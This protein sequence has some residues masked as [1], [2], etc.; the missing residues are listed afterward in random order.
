M[1]LWLSYIHTWQDAEPS[2]TRLI[3]EGQVSDQQAI[4]MRQQLNKLQSLIQQENHTDWYSKQYRI[5]FEQD[6][7]TPSG[8]FYRPDRVILKDNHAIVIDYKFGY[9]KHKS[10]LEQVRNYMLLLSQMGYT[11]EGHIVYNA[12]Q[13][14]H[15]IH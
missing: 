4:E 3:R 1:H 12:L 6:I 10:H 14:I 2:L 5:L 11:T 7:I 9:T 13:T 8:N 15:T